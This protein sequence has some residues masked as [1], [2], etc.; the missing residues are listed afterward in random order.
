MKWMICT[1]AF[2][3]SIEISYSFQTTKLF[4]GELHLDIFSCGQLLYESYQILGMQGEQGY[5]QMQCV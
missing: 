1:F 3:F 2:T 4:S 5:N